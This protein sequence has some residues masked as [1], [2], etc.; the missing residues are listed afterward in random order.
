MYS[1][2]IINIKNKTFKEENSKFSHIAIKDFYLKIPNGQFCCLIGPS[3]CGKTTILNIV[4]GL[5]LSKKSNVSFSDKSSY[6]QATIS[7]MFQTPRLLPWLNV[8]NNVNIVLGKKNKDFKRTEKILEIMGLK[9]FLY[10]YPN[11]LSGGMQRRVALARSF[12]TRPEILIL[13]EPFVSLNEPI[14]NMLREMLL[15]LWNEQPTTILFVTHDIREAIFLAD[16][17]VFLPKAPAKV[18]KEEKITISRPRMF[19]SND[20]EKERKRILFKNKNILDGIL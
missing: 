6:S 4:A 16:R 19:E 10:S 12:I 20:I 13:D 9:K 8:I 11:K 17:I 7:Y 3:G 2:L 15:K 14:A 18:I 5:D 1:E